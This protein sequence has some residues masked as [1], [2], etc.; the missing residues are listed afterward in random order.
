[1]RHDAQ[2]SPLVPVYPH[3]HILGSRVWW[4]NNWPI[5]NPALGEDSEA[6]HTWD[7]GAPPIMPP[8]PL[9]IGDPLC[10]LEGEKLREALPLN[11]PHRFQSWPLACG[12]SEPI[13]VW[14]EWAD[15]FRCRVQ[16]FWAQR[17]YELDKPDIAKLQAELMDI[18]G[19]AQFNYHPADGLFPSFCTVIHAD[20]SIAMIS[21]TQTAEQA[22]VEIMQTARPPTNQGNFSTAPLWLQQAT[23]VLGGLD[24]DNADPT[25]PVLFVGHS[26]GGAAAQIAAA[27]CRW[28]RRNRIIRFLTFG[29]PRIGDDRL[30]L[31]C[32]LPTRGCS[33]VNQG[34]IIGSIPPNVADA[35]PMAQFL[36]LPVLQWALWLSPNEVWVLQEDGSV[37]MNANPNLSTRALVALVRHAIRTGTFFGIPAHKIDAYVFRLLKRCAPINFANGRIRLNGQRGMVQLR[38]DIPAKGRVALKVLPAPAI[39]LRGLELA[40]VRLGVDRG[41]LGIGAIPL[42]P[43]PDGRI[44]LTQTGIRGDVGL[45]GGP[46]L[47][48]GLGLGYLLGGG[49]GLA[50]AAA[51]AG[52]VQ[53]R[54]DA[55]Q[56]GKLALFAES[57]PPYARGRLVLTERTA[58]LLAGQVVL[59]NP[60]G[61]R[62][63]IGFNGVLDA[64]QLALAAGLPSGMLGLRGDF[65]RQAQGNLVFNGAPQPV[66][67]ALGALVLSQPALPA[68]ITLAGTGANSTS[69]SLTFSATVAAGLLVVNAGVRGV[70][71]SVT[72]VTFNGVTMTMN[73]SAT[74]SGVQTSQWFLPVSAM[75]ANVVLSF[76]SAVGQNFGHAFSVTGLANNALD[77]GAVSTGNGTTGTVADSGTTG[78]SSV[79]TSAVIA[80]CV[81]GPATAVG[82]WGGT[83]AFSGAAS[84]TLVATVCTSGT[85]LASAT[86]TF[87]AVFTLSSGTFTLYAILVGTYN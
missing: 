73:T 19:D 35:L 59:A 3:P 44:A 49:L 25:K 14:G 78:T 62:G 33:L 51:L 81:Y 20:Y 83:P 31:A 40:A 74:Q 86:G 70:G 79:P 77:A 1:M 26:Y 7:N 37:L 72:G 56:L 12:F 17:Q 47:A 54:G 24:D 32:D 5:V 48:G 11:D 65:P 71:R 21:P 69:S 60:A 84:S 76:S 28:A 57:Y 46:A 41:Q 36:A 23:R 50:D 6:T 22:L 53:L 67:V 85:Y 29:A 10:V 42:L 68:T 18:F 52:K 61:L 64:A 58:G 38:G 87:D 13:D 15:V 9:F 63:G 27:M 55:V 30:K 4:E 16:L 75:T 2:G 39:V 66:P 43:M 80:C 45:S 82:T 8:D 34:D